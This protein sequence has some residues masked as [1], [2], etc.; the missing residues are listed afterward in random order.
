MLSE[1]HPAGAPAALL[2]LLLLVLVLPVSATG[3]PDAAA[4]RQY[5]YPMY[6]GLVNILI[7]LMC[8]GK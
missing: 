4:T 8:C 5:R 6:D 3:Q 2:L 7:W 1:L